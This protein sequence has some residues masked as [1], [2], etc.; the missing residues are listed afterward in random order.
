MQKPHHMF[1]TMHNQ[2]WRPPTPVASQPRW[3]R[4]Q[5]T[6]QSRGMGK[7]HQQQQL[8]RVVRQRAPQPQRDVPE[9]YKLF[10]CALLATLSI[11]QS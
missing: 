11:V 6:P 4:Q 1:M 10:Y 8:Q 5:Q 7:K 9:Q 2:R 3:G